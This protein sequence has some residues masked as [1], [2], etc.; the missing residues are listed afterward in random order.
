M[1][2]IMAASCMH[3]SSSAA[4]ATDVTTTSRRAC[5]LLYKS[6][7]TEYV[8]NALYAFAYTHVLCTASSGELRYTPLKTV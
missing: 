2:C 1:H 3:P 6:R 7:H 8:S 4:F 5:A